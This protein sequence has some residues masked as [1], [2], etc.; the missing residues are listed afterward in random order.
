MVDHADNEF[1]ANILSSCTYHLHPTF[2]NPIRCTTATPFVLE[3]QGWGQFDLKIVC[4]FIA[5]AGKFTIKHPLSFEDDAYAMDYRIQVPSHIPELRQFFADHL[6]L[7][8][9]VDEKVIDE[10]QAS[11]SW[12]S[13]V[14][15]LDEDAVADIVRMIV[16]HPAV[17]NEIFKH[18]RHEDILLALYQLPDDLLKEIGDFV[19][20]SSAT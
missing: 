7:P 12:V 20:R 5:C 8:P 17:K 1:D 14:P 3:E 11:L 10:Q 15:L 19:E 18:P 13:S 2:A 16:F 9:V 6:R 4:E